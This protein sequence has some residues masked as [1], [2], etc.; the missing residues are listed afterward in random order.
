[1]AC[2]PVGGVACGHVGHGM[3]RGGVAHGCR[4]SCREQ[5]QG[6]WAEPTHCSTWSWGGVRLLHLLPAWHPVAMPPLPPMG[7]DCHLQPW[8]A[9]GMGGHG[10]GGCGAWLQGAM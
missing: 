1:M 2:S 10:I 6:V 7:S 4:V 9:L 5:A 3:W 8:G